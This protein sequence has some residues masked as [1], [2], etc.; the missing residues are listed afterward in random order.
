MMLKRFVIR[1]EVLILFGFLIALL[2]VFNVLGVT[3]IDSDFFWAVAGCGL[4]LESVME[5][6]YASKE[7]TMVFDLGEEDRHKM[8]ADRMNNEPAGA[9]I[10]L[11]HGNIGVTMSYHTFRST[12]MKFYDSEKDD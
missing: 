2:S 11:A 10:T 9:V 12:M 1:H 3:N 8:L 6:V 7:E 4:V 5:L